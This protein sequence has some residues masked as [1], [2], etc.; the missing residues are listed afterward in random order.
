MSRRC[1]YAD[2]DIMEAYQKLLKASAWPTHCTIWTRPLLH[3]VALFPNP[4]CWHHQN[5]TEWNR[6][7]ESILNSNRIN[8]LVRGAPSWVVILYIRGSSSPSSFLPWNFTKA[9]FPCSQL[10]G[11]T[12]SALPSSCISFICCSCILSTCTGISQ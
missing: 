3:T 12:L 8:P 10:L 5:P 7:N 9:P 2:L 4:Y 6:F 1:M 11:Y